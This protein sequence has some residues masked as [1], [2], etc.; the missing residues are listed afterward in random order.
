MRSP[1][2]IN[3]YCEYDSGGRVKLSSRIYSQVL[4]AVSQLKGMKCLYLLSIF[5]CISLY[6]QAA[7]YT[8][9]QDGDWS[10]PA[11]WG[12]VY[13]S[14]FFATPV[15]GPNWFTSGMGDILILAH[16]VNIDYSVFVRDPDVLII[17]NSGS[18]TSATNA[19]YNLSSGDAGTTY[20]G[21][22]AGVFVFGNLSVNYVRNS[23]EW[24]ILGGVMTCNGGS[25]FDNYGDIYIRGQLNVDND[26]N[27]NAGNLEISG[28]GAV[29]VNSGNFHS[30]SSVSLSSITNCIEVTTGVFN[31]LLGATV[32]GSGVISAQGNI[33][34]AANAITNWTNVEWCTNGS[35]M[36]IPAGLED[37]GHPCGNPLPIELIAFSGVQ[38]GESV[39]LSWTTASEINNNYFTIEI[40]LDGFRFEL[41]GTLE[42]V[43]ISSSA[44]HYSMVDTNPM[45]GV[46]FYRLSQTDYDGTTE[47][48][49]LVSV[50][51][52]PMATVSLYPNPTRG[53]VYLTRNIDHTV[54]IYNQRG[55]REANIEILENSE[56]QLR[57]DIR[58]LENGQYFLR[59]GAF[60]SR[61]VKY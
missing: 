23:T 35:G 60:S 57:I 9:T 42:G 37:C 3:K 5:L 29:T 58:S 26:L 34:N 46:S 10:D 22:E 20:S 48:F 1:N 61:I 11:T 18:L 36:N 27:H 51:F 41:I 13:V 32:S 31:N 44:L 40:S 54:E 8:T 50:N 16:N 4:K 15:A 49:D 53:F 21:I 52:E 30:R 43:G 39:V 6:G 19:V 7:T 28:A 2:S 12:G 45:E 56:N 24:A 25:N 59:Y 14:S 55:R 38:D 33:D 17:T 47:Y